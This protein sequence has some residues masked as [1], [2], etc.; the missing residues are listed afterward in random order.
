MKKTITQVITL[1]LCI[2]MLSACTAPAATTTT[3]STAAATET[4]ATTEGATGTVATTEGTT[5]TPEPTTE[6][7]PIEPITFTM[8]AKDPN[9]QYENFESPVAKKITELTGVT[10]KMEYPVGDITQKIGLMIAGNDLPDFLFVAGELSKFID[11]G[12]I[13]DLTPY[14]NDPAKSSNFNKLYG[15]YVK[16]LRF[17]DEDHSMYHAGT[18]GVDEE[19]WEPSMGMEIQL[20]AVKEFGYPKITT[21][22]EAEKVIADYKA[23]YP[24]ID[25][26]PTIGMSLIAEDWRWMSG[27]GNMGAFLSGTGDDGQF[28]VDPKTH[29]T[30][31]RFTMDSHKQYFQWLNHLN[32]IGLLDPDSF[33]QSNDQ[34]LAKL[35]SGAVISTIAQSWQ[36][37]QA[38]TTL[39]SENKSER[40]FG[41]F[42]TTLDSSIVCGDFRDNGWSGGWGVAI[43]TSCKDPERA[44]AFIDWQCSDEA[45][46]LS[47]WG[48]EG[49]HYTVDADGKR[50]RNAD[51]ELA[52]TTNPNFGKETGIGVY[53]YPWPMRGNGVKDATGNTYTT[54]SP[55]TIINSY[56][57]I[58]KEVLQNYNAT[59]WRDLYPSKD[60]IA[61]SDWG[62]AWLVSIPT[63]DPI[64]LIATQCNDIVKQGIALSVMAPADQFEAEW[65]AMQKKLTDAGVEQLNAGFTALLQKQV[66]RWND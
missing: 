56:S 21:M 53:A 5:G 36:F 33:V 12:M 55:D 38:M 2:L 14:I 62:N 7:K 59:M 43:T 20:A 49:T 25:G 28:Y 46:I 9:N 19:K 27:I 6:A 44:W 13:L 24:T 51:V 31:F 16:R 23:K 26:V 47:N 52:A 58:E 57:D 64:N 18:F 65:A 37:S 39:K 17:S 63:D 48:I 50:V 3:A 29:E 60:K 8:F 42:P 10:L 22:E 45:Q 35:A 40:T 32:N 34:Y 61:V 4:V 1:L 11:A 41:Y 66:A 15:D 30:T 54:R